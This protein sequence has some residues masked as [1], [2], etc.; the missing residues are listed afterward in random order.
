MENETGG[1]GYKHYR[2]DKRDG[3]T[4]IKLTYVGPKGTKGKWERDRD[5]KWGEE[6]G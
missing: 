6:R 4:E 5:D 2:L 1:G 3:E